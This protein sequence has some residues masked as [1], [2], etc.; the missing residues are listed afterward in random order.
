MEELKYQEL[1][2]DFQNLVTVDSVPEEK[3]KEITFAS[4]QDRAK[5]TLQELVFTS[6][7][8]PI[9]LLTCAENCDIEKCI[10]DLLLSCE[11][12]ERE[13]HDIIYAENL[14]N[15]LAPTYLT[16]RS[17]TAAEFNKQIMDLLKK[18]E[19]K[20]NAEDDFMSIMK[21]QPGNTKLENYLSDLSIFMAKD[22]EL[23]YPVLMNLMVCHEKNQQ[24]VIYARDLTW[25]K[26][27]GGVN[28]LT[29]NG[30][31]YSHH[32]LLEAG[33]LRRADGGFLILPVS[34]LIHNPMLW[35]KLKNTL[36]SGQLDWENPIELSTNLVPFF[37]P[38]ETPINVKVILVGTYIEIASLYNIDPLC[39]KAFYLR[40]DI[41]TFFP[42]KEQ[43]A[44]FLGYLE[45]LA[46]FHKYLPLNQEAATRLL[47]FSCR[48]AENQNEFVLDEKELTNLICEASGLAG[49]RGLQE[50]T[51]EIIETTLK[52]REYRINLSEES[53]T[54]FFRDKQMLL[55]TNGEV[56][57]QIN[58][59]SVIS[60]FTE[61]FEYGEPTRI[62]ATIH[63]GGD[64]DISDV[65]H[66]ADLAG[67]I[68]TKAM[69][70]INGYLTNT[71]GRDE[72]IPVSANL[73]FEQS[74]NEIDGDSASLTGLCA[75]LSAM[76]HKP[77]RQTLSL[78]G[79]LDQLGNVQPVGGLNEKIEGFYR[80]CKIQ[81]FTGT[82]GVIIPASN[83]NSLIL[84]DEVVE[85]V[86]N[87]QFH[88]YTVTKVD[89]AIELLTGV[90]AG[91]I[92]GRTLANNLQEEGNAPENQENE[93]QETIYNII[94]NYLDDLSENNEIK[95]RKSGF[96]A[97][98]FGKN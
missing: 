23:T 52:N 36:D 73:V 46:E 82:Q 59:L 30:T 42:V 3:K 77:I 50:I 69:M 16:I 9:M 11:H 18:I 26:L 70:I 28:Y 64:G 17:G 43:G 33:L 10:K 92:E 13:L 60:T 53:S 35:F 95:I 65:E 98:I 55:Q 45:S 79:S 90:K 97:R 14:D 75:I 89:E 78:T 67:Q 27:F 54:N 57:G 76:A 96:F 19:H 34:E 72:S 68:H 61:D 8:N 94:R 48:L 88:I 49:R 44:N 87:G 86:K 5:N 2:P 20:L 81:G 24:P 1:L 83:K 51:G 21:K 22:G 71:F 15:A 63:S 7:P 58:G 74:Y 29:E 6:K 39:S 38:E 62:T 91:L 37:N 56:I 25:K 85:A 4:F 12:P 47:R 31:T 80:I 84:S 93:S 41:T 66:K 32:H 40:T